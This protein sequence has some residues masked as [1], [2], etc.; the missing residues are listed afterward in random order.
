M[1]DISNLV[2][3]EKFA[4]CQ[5]ISSEGNK[6]WCHRLILQLRCPVFEA[7]F[8]S[9]MKESKSAMTEIKSDQDFETTLQF[10]TYIYTD[11]CDINA[12]NVCGLLM[13][14]TYYKIDRLEAMCEMSIKD[15]VDVN[16]CAQLLG[17]ADQLNAKPL[18]LFLQEYIYDNIQEVIQTPSWGQLDKALVNAILLNSVNRH[19]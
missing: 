1:K 4:D 8:A 11:T 9:G 6:I 7:M 15:C 10:L 2:N 17:I 18:I 3:N 16:N 19:K 12:N 13:L 5:F 14:A